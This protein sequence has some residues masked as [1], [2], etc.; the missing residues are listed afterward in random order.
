M[1]LKNFQDL[2][3]KRF[4]KEEVA[5][6]DREVEL[7][8]NALRSLQQNVKDALD[9]YMKKH[10]VGFNE[11]VRRL[12]TSPRKLAQ[13]QKGKANLTFA[14]VAQISAMLGQ[15]PTITFKKK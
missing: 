15:E 3:E 13:I 7:E 14:S 1:K 9:A 4:T 10:D 6:I 11:V 2:I 8:S 12:N 5:A